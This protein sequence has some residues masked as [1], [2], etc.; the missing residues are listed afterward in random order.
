VG[1]TVYCA[2]GEGTVV[3]V[4]GKTGDGSQ[5]VEIRLATASAPFYAACSN[6]LVMPG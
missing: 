5:L 3:S 6:V 1:E 2:G 4:R